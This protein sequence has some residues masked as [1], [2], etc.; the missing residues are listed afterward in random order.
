MKVIIGDNI[1]KVKLC[2]TP[3]SISKGMM[4]KKFDDSFNGMLFMMPERG[5]QSFWMKKCIIPL[6]IIFID[7][8]VIT[9]IHKNCKPCEEK[10]LCKTYRGLG[11]MVL[12]VGGGECDERGISTGDSVSTSMV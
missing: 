4:N 7:K 8:G 11:D 5:E 10:N 3:F 9:K 6:D 12:E 2:T 1:F